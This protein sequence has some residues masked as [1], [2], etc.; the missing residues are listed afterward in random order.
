ML[1]TIGCILLALFFAPLLT[2]HFKQV[3]RHNR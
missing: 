3:S 2:A 1:T